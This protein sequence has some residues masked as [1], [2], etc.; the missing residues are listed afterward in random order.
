MLIVT[1]FPPPST[2]SSSSLFAPAIFSLPFHLF[3]N[4]YHFPHSSLVQCLLLKIYFLPPHILDFSGHFTA[5]VYTHTH[6]YI[7]T[8]VKIVYPSN[9]CQLIACSVYM[10][11]C[12]CGCLCRC[13]FLV[14][15]RNCRN[16]LLNNLLSYSWTNFCS[17]LVSLTLL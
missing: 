16:F 13:K 15:K 12:L 1:L 5:W 4:F 17:Q 7:D 2:S 14:I 8:C 3:H 9:C 11:S 10:F 6:T